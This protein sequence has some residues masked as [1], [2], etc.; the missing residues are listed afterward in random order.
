M[1]PELTSSRDRQVNILGRAVVVAN[2]RAPAHLVR[3]IPVDHRHI[4]DWLPS[5]TPADCDC[6]E[7]QQLI[8]E[9]L[10]RRELSGDTEWTE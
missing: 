9:R 10:C 3:Q 2:D 5:P 4:S 1:K 8:F 6:Q 7:Q